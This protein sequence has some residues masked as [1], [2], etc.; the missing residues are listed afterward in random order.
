MESAVSAGL[1]AA[2]GLSRIGKPDVVAEGHPSA[3]HIT[4]WSSAG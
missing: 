2:I 3:A 1:V 4:S